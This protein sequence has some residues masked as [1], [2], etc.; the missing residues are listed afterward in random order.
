MQCI[1]NFKFKILTQERGLLL[2]IATYEV[3]RNIS[4][5]KIIKNLCKTEHPNYK[6][7]MIGYEARYALR[8]LLVGD[9][10]LQIYHVAGNTLRFKYFLIATGIDN[11]RFHDQVP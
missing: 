6:G 4:L 2:I 8:H 1:T 3:R 9:S 10:E 11:V 7:D 5:K